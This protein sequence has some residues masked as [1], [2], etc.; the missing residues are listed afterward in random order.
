MCAL[1][2][3]LQFSRIMDCPLTAELPVVTDPFPIRALPTLH[4]PF[5]TMP[6]L[7]GSMPF[8]IRWF[9]FKMLWDVFVSFHGIASNRRS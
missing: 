1:G 8:N 5:S 2:D 6:S 7:C 4:A 9:A 3:I